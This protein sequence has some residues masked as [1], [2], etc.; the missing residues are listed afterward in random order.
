MLLCCASS[1]NVIRQ[2]VYSWGMKDFSEDNLKGYDTVINETTNS[3]YF[4]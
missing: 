3:R 2:E 1:N 4:M